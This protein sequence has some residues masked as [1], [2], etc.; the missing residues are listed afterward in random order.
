MIILDG[1]LQT[2]RQPSVFSVSE[3]WLAFL[4]SPVA[5]VAL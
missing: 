4:E 2:Y 5:Q 3:Y 1:Q